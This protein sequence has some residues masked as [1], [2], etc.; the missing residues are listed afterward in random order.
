MTD[1]KATS[2]VQ[3][4]ALKK[5]GG[6]NKFSTQSI[7]VTIQI[8]KVITK[9][10]DRIPIKVLNNSKNYQVSFAGESEYA[11]VSVTGS[12]AKI[13]ALTADNIQATVDIDGLKVGSRKVD[14]DVA[15][16]DEQLKIELLSSSKI[17]INIERN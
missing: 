16:D 4:V 14:V 12:E 13:N 11:S 9:R 5:V 10:F 3:G 8:E 15:I 2:T 6:I 7:D 17:T 1:M